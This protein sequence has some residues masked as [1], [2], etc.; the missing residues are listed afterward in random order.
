MIAGCLEELLPDATLLPRVLEEH[1]AFTAGKTRHA[2]PSAAPRLVNIAGVPGAGKSTLA[3]QVLQEE[4][5]LLYLSFDELME[6]LS[7]YREDLHRHG[8]AVAF[9]RW[10]L[11]ARWLGYR[12]LEECLARRYS[13]LFEHGNATPAHVD[14][15]RRVKALG[16]RLEI[17][18]IDVPLEVAIERA[19]QRER[20]TPREVVEERHALLRELNETYKQLADSFEIIQA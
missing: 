18:F 19:G 4:P 11:P 10:E 7:P 9:A 2:T 1:A 12:F 15:Y 5:A 20:Y 13:L 6:G 8:A 16:Y 3:R 17:R 14:L